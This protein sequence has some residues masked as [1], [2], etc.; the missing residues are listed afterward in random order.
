MNSRQ[1]NFYLTSNDLRDLEAVV[2]PEMDII[3]IEATCK[4]VPSVL[5]S[6]I[7][8]RMGEDRLQI[9]L[10]NPQ[11]LSEIVVEPVKS[12]PYKLVDV[13]KSPAIEFLRCFES[14]VT[15]R[16][17]RLYYIVNYLDDKGVLIRKNDTFVNWATLLFKIVKRELQRDNDGLYYGRE[18]MELRGRLQFLT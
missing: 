6:T 4:D 12:Q 7:V 10:C 9:F 11:Q 13:L 2:R 1:I 15:L 18:A 5:E 3:P 8:K 16:R 17:G 14:E